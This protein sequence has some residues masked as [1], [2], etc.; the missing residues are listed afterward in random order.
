MTR[1]AAPF[2]ILFPDPEP[3][4]LP[5][6]H[7]W[8]EHLADLNL[9]QVFEIITASRREY[10]LGAFL[11]F[12]LPDERSVAY[13]QAVFRDLELGVSGPLEDFAG[14]MR[15]MRSHLSAAKQRRHHYE[16]AAWFLHAGQIYCEAVASLSDALV[17]ARPRSDGLRRWQEYLDGYVQSERFRQVRID[18]E[19]I[20][21]ELD[22]IRYCVRVHGGQV[23]VSDYQGERDYSAE[24]LASFQKFRV[25][26]VKSRLVKFRH[27]FQN[28]VQQ[29]I[30]DRVALLHPE[31]FET[32]LG[33]HRTNAEL[34]DPV[35]SRFDR[36][37]QLYLGYLSFIAPLKEAGLHFFYPEVSSQSREV[38]AADA[39]DLALA[40]KLVGDGRSVV[41]NDV[42]L[43]GGER[44]AVI[45]GP[46][47][48]GKTTF[49]RTFGQLHYLAALGFP[50]PGT[51]GRIFLSDRVLTHFARQEQVED[52]HSGLE[53]ELLRVREMLDQATS[54][55]VVVMNES[56][57]S[58]TSDDQLYLG[59]EI[60][61]RLIEADVL[62]VYVTFIDELSRMG[63]SVVS[64]MSTVRPNN[65]AE[66]TFK[67]VRKPADGRAYA[68]VIAE[69][70]GLTYDLVTGRMQP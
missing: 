33:Y 49:A 28:H 50:V 3:G 27:D 10:D 8:P 31:L 5:A 23:M 57:A 61:E 30:V 42:E 52:L 11:Q 16:K 7:A 17:R 19:R 13:R 12:P 37:A 47:Q 34:V 58:T 53:D 48:G 21:Q 22:G 26:D 67:V 64:M 54:R 35:I 44:I 69:A 14:R 62:A 24:V 59:R 36:E 39:F 65:P 46:N 63:P 9:D 43:Q 51:G 66:R 68:M 38:R 60:I 29:L 25:G 70:H 4:P 18:T 1:A 32:L 45:S 15:R 41:V 2:S 55:S 20:A 6:A 40:R 56:F